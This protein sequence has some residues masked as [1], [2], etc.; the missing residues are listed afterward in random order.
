MSN[1]IEHQIRPGSVMEKKALD[2]AHSAVANAVTAHHYANLG[3]APAM[4]LACVCEGIRAL[5]VLERALR[6]E[7]RETPAL[8]APDKLN[9][10]TP[11]K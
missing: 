10:R 1:D 11:A 4:T 8:R 3:D 6:A 7:L 2:A 9:E 5:K